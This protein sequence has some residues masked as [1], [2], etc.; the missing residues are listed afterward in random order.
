M[1]Q[2]CYFYYGF[3]VANRQTKPLS[4]L[5]VTVSNMQ[6]VAHYAGK[7]QHLMDG[8]VA[9]QLIS[10]HGRVCVSFIRVII[11]PCTVL[12]LISLRQDKWSIFL[13][14]FLL[15]WCWHGP[16]RQHERKIK[17]KW[18]ENDFFFFLREAGELFWQENIL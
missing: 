13:T 6:P 15:I 3:Q 7:C 14:S 12:C 1:F 8:P 5:V 11:F 4:F 16:C 18:D 17:R 2:Q 9:L 10:V